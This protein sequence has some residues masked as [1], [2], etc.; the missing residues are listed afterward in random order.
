VGSRD[1]AF[2]RTDAGASGKTQTRMSDRS[3]RST[4]LP[5][6]TPTIGRDCGRPEA[7]LLSDVLV[8]A[9]SIAR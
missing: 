9:T 6:A 2:D 1:D 3:S 7:S 8:S 4:K 5:G